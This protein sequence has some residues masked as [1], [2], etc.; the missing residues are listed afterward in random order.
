MKEW[1]RGPRSPHRQACESLPLLPQGG[2]RGRE[3]PQGQVMSAGGRRKRKLGDQA[4][5]ARR[6]GGASYPLPSPQAS[7]EHKQPQAPQRSLALGQL[8]PGL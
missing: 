8:P 7:W 4:K 5:L 6:Q 3:G 2:H 1:E